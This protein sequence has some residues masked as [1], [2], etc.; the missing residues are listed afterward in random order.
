MFPSGRKEAGHVN[1][2]YIAGMRDHFLRLGLA[3]RAVW[4]S[5]KSINQNSRTMTTTSKISE[6]T[7]RELLSWPGVMAGTHRFGGREFRIGNHEIG[8]LHGGDMADLPFPRAIRDELVSR[9]EV[10]PHHHLPDS[11]WV[12]FRFGG[13]SDIPV[14][15]E[16]FRRNYK[17]LRARDGFTAKTKGR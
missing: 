8:H 17:R 14:A 1:F 3:R 6:A 4:T 7:E 9:G 12:S 5:R 16:L 2:F 15:L 13:E 10:S 11:G